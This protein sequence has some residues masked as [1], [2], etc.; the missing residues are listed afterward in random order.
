MSAIHSPIEQPTGYPPGNHAVLTRTPLSAGRIAFFLAVA[1][2]VLVGI[3]IAVGELGIKRMDQINA[4]FEDILGRRWNK[5]QLS[6]EALAYSN[7]N[8]RITMLVFLTQDKDQTDQLL[9]TRAENTRKIAELLAQ[10][11]KKCDSEEEKRL[12][13]AVQRARV[14]YIESYLHALHLLLEEHRYDAAVAVMVQQTTP[15]LRQYQAAWDDFVRFQMNQVELAARQSRDNYA[16]A[17]RASLLMIALAVLVMTLVALLV[18]RMI[19]HETQTRMRAERQIKELNGQLEHRVSER[20]R[21]LEDANQRLL[22]EIRERQTAEEQVKFLA[23]YD[24]LTGLLNRNLLEDRMRVALA[25]ARRRQEKVAVLYIDLDNFKNVNDSLGHAAGD[26]LLK[27]VAHRLKKYTREQDTVARLGGDEFIIVLTALKEIADAALTA[28]RITSEIIKDYVIQNHQLSVTCS[29]GISLFP[30]H[31]SDVAT[32]IKNA[33]AA[34]Y[35]VKEN[36]RNNSQFF[37]ESLTAYADE[38]LAL[39]SSLRSAVERNQLFLVY[40]AQVDISSGNITGSEALLRWRHPELGLVPPDKFIPIAENSG[41]ILP[42]GEWVL[43]TACQQAK[44]WQDEGLAVLPVSVNVS[45]IQFRQKGFPELVKKVLCETGLSPMHLELELTEGLIILSAEVVLSVLEKLTEMGVR[46]SIDDF[47]T[48]YSN[49]SYLR[50]FPVY[51]LKIDRSFVKD[52]AVD[53]DDAAITAAIISMAKS[54]DLRVIAEGVENEEQMAMLRA[55]H[56]DECQ[57]YYFSMPQPADEF[58]ETVLRRF[59]ENR[60]ARAYQDS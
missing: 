8:V 38:K 53:P 42:I 33:D 29:L 32:L 2:T 16:T 5:L 10:I 50:Q 60:Q 51:K 39:E 35:S 19:V 55:Q 23:H 4:D 54:L 47:G 31:A 49:L 52:V 44:R 22:T 34:M 43:R 25:N 15:A 1:F 26:L 14:V 18:V 17:R 9:A 24:S 40:Q 3:L 57:G 13:A 45:P 12:V 7:R 41:L 11:E 21:E 46:L 30:D 28:E 58:A 36:G 48:G 20:T 37:T 56:C 6:R 59:G 27:E